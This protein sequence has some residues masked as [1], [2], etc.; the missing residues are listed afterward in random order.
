MVYER[1]LIDWCDHFRESH[2][3]LGRG[4]RFE[5][6]TVDLSGCGIDDRG[7]DLLC[8]TLEE[9]GAAVTK[10]KLHRNRIGNR[11]CKRLATY[12]Y[13]AHEL[14][15]LHLSH[16]RI[17]SKGAAYL[18]LAIA[19]NDRYP[20]QNESGRACPLW[21]RLENNRIEFGTLELAEKH[22][23]ERR[24][25]MG[26]TCPEASMICSVNDFPS[27]CRNT[28]CR[29]ATP[30]WP[31]V[32]LTH[33]HSQDLPLEQ[34]QARQLAQQSAVLPISPPPPPTVCMPSAVEGSGEPALDE[35]P[36]FDRS[37]LLQEPAPAVLSVPAEGA[38]Q[39]VA[40]LPVAAAT[41]TAAPVDHPPETTSEEPSR[42]SSSL[43]DWLAAIR[44]EEYW[45]QLQEHGFDELEDLKAA[46]AEELEEMFRLAGVKHGHRVRWRQALATE[47]GGSG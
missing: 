42:V 34:L 44:L 28:M 38:A 23:R 7:V 24:D 31:L 19:C 46:N 6:Q 41:A 13:K 2:K 27:P 12:L 26:L 15:E 16:N 32:H 37:L 1:N 10:L 35:R 30:T 36:P 29:K 21:L 3:R 9:T 20:A 40:A 47:H 18:F 45:P 5:Q 8:E 39:S 43:R 17:T 22:M 25:R 4:G 33:F 14:W 11:G